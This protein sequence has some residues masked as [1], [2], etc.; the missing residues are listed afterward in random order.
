MGPNCSISAKNDFSGEIR[1][2]RI[3]KS[4]SIFHTFSSKQYSKF[5]RNKADILYSYQFSI[6][7]IKFADQNSSLINFATNDHNNF[8]SYNSSITF[9]SVPSLHILKDFTMGK[10]PF[11]INHDI[12]RFTIFFPKIR[13]F[14]SRSALPQTLQNSHNIS[15]LSSPSIFSVNFLSYFLCHHHNSTTFR[16]KHPILEFQEHSNFPSNKDQQSPCTSE[17]TIPLPHNSFLP[18]SPQISI[19]TTLSVSPSA[20][21]KPYSSSFDLLP[22]TCIE[23]LHTHQHTICQAKFHHPSSLT[24]ITQF[25][26]SI[27]HE[28]TC[29]HHQQSHLDFSHCVTRST[30]DINIPIILP[31][32]HQHNP[33]TI[34]LLAMSRNPPCSLICTT[35]NNNPIHHSISPPPQPHLQPT[36]PQIEPCPYS[37]ITTTIATGLTSFIDVEFIHP[38]SSST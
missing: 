29:Q 27:L 30:I 33:R 7:H 1:L 26:R 2:I 22:P 8:S 11:Q 23:S 24:H 14:T 18:I 16:S 25:H 35:H 32:I 15:Q 38:P 36:V 20:V 10:F 34:S 9:N 6:D 28:V 19:N 12:P 31:I 5:K 37:I 4:P 13:K 3:P 17:Y 21:R